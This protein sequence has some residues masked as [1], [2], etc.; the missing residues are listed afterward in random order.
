MLN[1]EVGLRPGSRDHQPIFGLTDDP[2][3]YI[4][5]GHYRHG[6]VLSAVTAMES[7]KSILSGAE[8]TEVCVFLTYAVLPHLER[9][10]MISITVNGSAEQASAEA[11]LG[12]VLR[13]RAISEESARGV[14]V[15]RR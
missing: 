13:A 2:R 8:S 12:D 4:A 6:V 1:A 5:T 11:T 9:M 7:T 3:L 10:D 15:A 14:A